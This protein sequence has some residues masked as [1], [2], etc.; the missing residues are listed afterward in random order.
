MSVAEPAAHV[1]QRI[2][3]I[4]QTVPYLHADSQ[5]AAAWQARLAS[6]SPHLKVGLAWA[7]K[8]AQVDDRKRSMKLAGFA[9]LARVPG[10]RFFSL[11]KGP[12]LLRPNLRPPGMELIDWTAGLNDFADTAA[13]IANLD[14]IISV[15]TAVVHLAGAMGKPVWTLLSL[16]AD[17][18][19]P[20]DRAGSPWYPTMRLFRQRTRGDWASVLAQ[21]AE[22]MAGQCKAHS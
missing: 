12:P 2:Y 6:Q 9:P 13:L 22:A 21:V 15:D 11:Q 3:P 20:R 18:R 16:T 8:P 4:P 1:A 14:L 5:V 7:G 19:Y 10:V 17:W